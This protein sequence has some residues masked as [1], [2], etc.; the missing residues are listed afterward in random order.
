MPTPSKSRRGLYSA[1]SLLLAAGLAAALS[2][3]YDVYVHWQP[4]VFPYTLVVLT[5]G[6]AALTLFALLARGERK[7]ITLLWKTALSMLAFTG[8]S[9]CGVSFVINNVVGHEAMARQA[10]M[11]S[12]PLA[13]I[14]ILA[15]CVL[16]LSPA[17]KRVAR[18]WIALAAALL[19][20]TVGVGVAMPWY[21][22]E[23]YR[24]P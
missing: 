20:V 22:R 19:L 14:Q 2:W 3:Y 10:S 7:A 18:K 15:L 13:A 1:L 16:A 4:K 6:I 17:G 12:L 8:V 11:V 23:K 5:L 9:L 24:A 21:Y